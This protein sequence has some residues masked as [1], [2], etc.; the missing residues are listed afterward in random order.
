MFKQL[1]YRLPFFD[2]IYIFLTHSSLQ[3]IYF[4]SIISSL[5]L[6]II[7]PVSSPMAISSYFFVKSHSLKCFTSIPLK[8]PPFPFNTCLK[9]KSGVFEGVDGDITALCFKLLHFDST[10]ILISTLLSHILLSCLPLL[11]LKW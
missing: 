11:L 6:S 4:P 8:T 9:S 3:F 10:I 7:Y 1:F 2:R 5:A